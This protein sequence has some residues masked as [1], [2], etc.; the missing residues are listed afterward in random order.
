MQLNPNEFSLANYTE[1]QKQEFSSN[2]LTFPKNLLCA[3]YCA[4]C[5]GNLFQI[6]VKAQ[7]VVFKKLTE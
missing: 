1:Q 2:K 7:D 6:I 5:S 4:N 3:W